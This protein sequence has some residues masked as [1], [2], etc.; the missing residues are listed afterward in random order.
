MVYSLL[1]LFVSM[2]RNVLGLVPSHFKL[3]I[4]F[5]Q[6]FISLAW[7]SESSNQRIFQQGRHPCSAWFMRELYDKEG[8]CWKHHPGGSSGCEQ[9]GEFSHSASNPTVK[10]L[11]YQLFKSPAWKI[12]LP[13]T[14]TIHDTPLSLLPAATTFIILSH[15]EFPLTI[16]TSASSLWHLRCRMISSE[17]I[18]A[19]LFIIYYT[20][21][22]LFFGFCHIFINFASKTI[23]KSYPLK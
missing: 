13:S 15:H 10:N 22:E 6:V 11:A 19:F 8:G 7:I 1:S 17:R 21:I 12:R 23:I 18:I 3:D 4:I 2:G 9:M 20:F 14:S 5:L 16:K